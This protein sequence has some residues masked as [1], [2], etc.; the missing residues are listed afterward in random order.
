V[1]NWAVVIQALMRTK[2]ANSR[3]KE[4]TMKHI[5]DLLGCSMTTV[6]RCYNLPSKVSNDTKIQILDVAQ[7]LGYKRED[8]YKKVKQEFLT[9]KNDSYGRPEINIENVNLFRKQGKTIKEI[10]QITGLS[11]LAISSAFIRH[12]ILERKPR[13]NYYGY[14]K[15]EMNTKGSSFRKKLSQIIKKY[16]T[17]I[18]YSLSCKE[19]GIDRYAAMHVFEKSKAYQILKRRKQATQTLLIS[20]KYPFER[21]MTQNAERYIKSLGVKTIEKERCLYVTGSG[22]GKGGFTCDFYASETNTVYELKQR[23]TTHSNKSLFGQIFIYKTCGHNVAVIF[24]DDVTITQSLQYALDANQVT[25]HR[26]P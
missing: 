20:K 10:S 22:H 6:H 24:P 2:S 8:K 3:I 23:T 7:K 19:L 11:V 15:S 17:G 9:G 21:D 12:G 25:V 13:P 1:G 4:V 26:L 5:A 14:V 18:P 16:K